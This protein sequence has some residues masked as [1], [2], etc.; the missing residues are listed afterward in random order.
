MFIIL[1]TLKNTGFRRKEPWFI[2]VESPGMDSGK[3]V[4][5]SGMF[6]V[7]DISSVS[8]CKTGYDCGKVFHCFPQNSNMVFTGCQ[9]N[10]MFINK[11]LL[12]TIWASHYIKEETA[13]KINLD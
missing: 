12:I 11:I 8:G 10:K 7:T 4:E 1:Q 6:R 5:R 9:Q 13:A 3:S 2:P